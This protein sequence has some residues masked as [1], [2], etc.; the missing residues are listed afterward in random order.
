[1]QGVGI[2]RTKNNDLCVV[3]EKMDGTLADKIREA[4]KEGQPY[5]EWK[6]WYYFMQVCRAIDYMH[7]MNIIHMD[8]KAD[9]VL[10]KGRTA[11]ITDYTLSI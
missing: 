1:M 3:M 9:N 4:T 6:I 7:Q 8:I 10:I 5:E 2:G 11:R